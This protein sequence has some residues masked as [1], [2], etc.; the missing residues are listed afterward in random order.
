MIHRLPDC[1]LLAIFDHYREESSQE[2]TVTFVWSWKTLTHVCR[3]WRT[4][5]IASPR[6][7]HL[8]VICS[9][10]TP[11]KT[12]LDIWP[13]FPIAVVC[14]APDVIDRKGEENLIAALEHRDRISEIYI[15]DQLGHSME[16]LAATMQKPF[17]ALTDLYLGSLMSEPPYLSDAFL[18]GSAPCLRSFTLDYVAF[19]SFSKFML[20]ATNLVTLSVIFIPDSGY[21]FP[22][23]G[24]MVTYLAALPRLKSLTIEFLSVPSNSHQIIFPQ[25]PVVL[26]ALEHFRFGGVNEYLEDFVPRIDAPLLTQFSIV[27][28]L[29]TVFNLP[30]LYNFISRTEKLL[31]HNHA[32]ML[33]DDDMS[34]IVLGSPICFELE[35]ISEETGWQ[36]QSMTDVCCRYLP[37]LSQVVQLDICEASWMTVRECKEMDPSLWLEFFRLFNGVQ[38]LSVSERWEPLVGAALREL[39]GGRTMEVLPSLQSL[40]LDELGPSGSARDAM[41]PFVA[42]RQL[43]GRPIVVQRRKRQ[44]MQQLHYY[45]IYVFRG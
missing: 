35:L 17:P 4:L 8:R 41:E 2:S 33:F 7:L 9:L 42:A 31:P 11:V 26:P 32:Q 20:N 6:R 30:Q 3:R 22:S 1:P 29:D 25:T 27:L 14:F 13:P 15:W 19:P 45:H 12:S 39:T 10:R 40:S 24:E 34:K 23:P 38:S 43:S 21:I 37:F 36:L 44:E 16:R 18:G 5:I 28:F